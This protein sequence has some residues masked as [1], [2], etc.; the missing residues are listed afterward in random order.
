MTKQ[1]GIWTANNSSTS[2][3]GRARA[4]LCWA[5]L[6]FPLLFLKQSLVAEHPSPSVS[7]R[8]SWSPRVSPAQAPCIGL[9]ESCPGLLS[10]HSCPPPGHLPVHPTCHPVPGCVCAIPSH[11]SLFRD[12]V[13][14][15][16]HFCPLPWGG[17]QPTVHDISYFDP[18]PLLAPGERLYKVSCLSKR[19]FIPQ[20]LHI[21]DADSG[22]G[23]VLAYPAVGFR[24]EKDS[25]HAPKSK[26]NECDS[27]PTICHSAK[28]S[29]QVVSL[30]SPSAS[31]VTPQHRDSALMSF[32]YLCSHSLLCSPIEDRSSSRLINLP[33]GRAEKH[34]TGI[35]LTV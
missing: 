18:I 32:S 8:G 30:V 2:L 16:W 23:P 31:I 3:L 20:T 4:S 10:L 25:I 19:S 29:S 21:G 24:K 11:R 28:C 1:I 26:E 13:K 14:L 35:S 9:G 6:P 7:W 17:G 5:L 15:P 22:P 27:T 33:K 34:V 12:H